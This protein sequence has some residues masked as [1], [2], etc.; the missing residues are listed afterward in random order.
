MKPRF[1]RAFT[2]PRPSSDPSA[3]PVVFLHIPKTAG[4]S[5]IQALL[6]MKPWR[7]TLT[8][9]GNITPELLRVY[10]S[11]SAEQQPDTLIYGHAYHA[12]F[13][14][15][16]DATLLTVLR[17]PE[18]QAVSH[19]L[20]V[21][22]SPDSHLYRDAH[23]LPFADFL[24]KHWP[25]LVFQNISL[26]V[27]NSERPIATR[28]DFFSRLP[29][30][31]RVLDRIDFVGTTD[32]LCG[33]VT[34]LSRAFAVAEPPVQYLHRAIDFGIS[35][36]EIAA[37]RA[38][39]RAVAEEPALARLAA[40]ERALY[41]AAKRKAEARQHPPKSFSRKPWL[42]ANRLASANKFRG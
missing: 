27:P 1:W 31:R 36:A 37:L 21:L 18:E 28:D 10:G 34:A 2:R 29:A 26:D 22:R 4:T 25:C 13:P 14:A 38:S 30:I 15:F 33:F 12:T 19:Y 7:N 8:D 23:A 3:R 11:L 20:H 17:D 6:A 41:Q 32:D 5:L 39:Y 24:R 40:E 35:A 42:W 9:Q 16:A